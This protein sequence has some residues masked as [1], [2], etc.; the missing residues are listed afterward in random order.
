MS[1]KTRKLFSFF[2][3]TDS[4]T[5]HSI[6]RTFVFFN[7]LYI[8]VDLQIRHKGDTEKSSYSALH[9]LLETSTCVTV[10]SFLLMG[11]CMSVH[12]Y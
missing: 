5:S 11:Q 12:Y 6:F 3:I 2:K 4:K 10:Y 9:F 7:I 1:F 8:F